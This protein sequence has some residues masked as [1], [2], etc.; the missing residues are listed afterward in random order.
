M[1]DELKKQGIKV[2]L[3]LKKNITKRRFNDSIKKE[4]VFLK[5]VNWRIEIIVISNEIV[6]VH[7]FHFISNNNYQL[8]KKNPRRLGF[9]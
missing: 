5:R 9:I 7:F 2:L 6:N 8:I 4:A 1:Y 3:S